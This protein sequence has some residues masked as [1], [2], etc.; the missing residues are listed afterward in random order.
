MLLKVGVFF[1]VFFGHCRRTSQSGFCDS[2]G[3]A[4]RGREISAKTI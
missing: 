2:S 1:E 3:F 4:G